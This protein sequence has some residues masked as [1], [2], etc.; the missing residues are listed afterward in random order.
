MFPD[1]GSPILSQH[2]SAIVLAAS[3][4]I[5]IFESNIWGMLFYAAQVERDQYNGTVGI[6]LFE[7]V[8]Y[9][10]LFVRHAATMVQSLGYSGP[11]HI[12]TALNSLLGAQWLNPQGN[13]FSAQRGSELGDSVTFSLATTSNVLRDARLMY[14]AE[15]HFPPRSCARCSISLSSS[16]RL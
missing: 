2:E 12:E 13:W 6:H 15:R 7:F 9:L 10:L 16:R 4:G 14:L 8:G 3:R 5:S 1:P 11:I